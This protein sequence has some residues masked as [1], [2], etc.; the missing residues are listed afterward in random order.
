VPD[1][2][3]TP[4]AGTIAASIKAALGQNCGW[5][6]ETSKVELEVG[7]ATPG[8]TGLAAARAAASGGTPISSNGEPGYFAV[9]NGVGSAQFFIGTLWL[10]VSSADFTVPGDAQ[11]VYSVVVHNQMTA[12]G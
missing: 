10:D 11:P 9:Q 5:V 3:Y 7:V 2:G 6:N 12:G 1:S 8:A 4:K